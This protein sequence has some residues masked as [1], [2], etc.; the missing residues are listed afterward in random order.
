MDKKHKIEFFNSVAKDRDRWKNKNSYYYRKIAQLLKFSIPEGSTVLE[1]GCGTGGLL[2]DLKPSRGV[3]VDFSSR[4]VEIA[5]DKYPHLTFIEMD[6]E[7]LALNEKFDYVVMS[8]MIGHIEDVQLMFERL[9]SVCHPK[10][11]IVI[12][13]YN[14]A[15]EGI[16]KTGEKL[17]FKMREFMQNWLSKHDIKN[18]L[19]LA[20]FEEIRVGGALLFPVYIPIISEFLNKYLSKMFWLQNLCFINYVIARP[21]PKIFYGNDDFSCSVIIPARNERENIERAV[22]E[23]PQ[24]GKFTEI[25]FVEGNSTDN[26]LQEIQRVCEKYKDKRN[27]KYAVQDGRGKKDAVFKGFDM[28]SGDILMIVDA[29]LTVSSRDLPKFYNAIVSG[30]GEFINGSRFVYPREKEAMRF[31]RILANKFFSLLFSWI[32]GQYLK[33]TLCGTK[34]IMKSDY[35]KL[36]KD[37]AY[38][39]DFDKYGDFDLILGSYKNSLKI[40]EVPIHYKSRTYGS[41]NISTWKGGSILLRSALFAMKKVKFI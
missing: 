24:M 25:I 19:N 28:A 40:V 22:E 9:H 32:L 15:W 7:N 23:I 2:N 8:D 21:D 18:L 11:K 14:F 34:V 6:A 35:E 27:L 31:L 13:Y 12:T 3:G 37:S 10:T 20:N 39:G 29:D 16:L 38:F 5:K 4:M 36:K 26:T 1:L 17:K 33:D 30:M 41:T